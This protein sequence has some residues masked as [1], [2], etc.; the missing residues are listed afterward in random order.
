MHVLARESFAQI[1]QSSFISGPDCVKITTVA[2]VLYSME[3]HVKQPDRFQWC[4][5]R[6][7]PDSYGSALSGSGLTNENEGDLP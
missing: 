6:D 2:L 3:F 7:R 1:V 5:C 4:S